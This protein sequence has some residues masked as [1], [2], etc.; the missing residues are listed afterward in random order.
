MRW[1]GSYRNVEATWL[2]WASLA[3]EILPTGQEL[4]RRERQRAELLADK[5]RELGI[6]PDD[7]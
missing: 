3:G 1:A 7:L 2:R 5:L 6:D 4:A